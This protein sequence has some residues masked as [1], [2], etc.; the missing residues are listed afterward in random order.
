MTHSF[1]VARIFYR[2]G[3]VSIALILTGLFCL[4]ASAATVQS[5]AYVR[6]IHASPFI[7]TADVFVDGKQLLSSFQF[8]AVTGYVPV[9]PGTHKVQI[10]IMG[11]GINA[12]VITQDLTVTAGYAYTVA[13]LGTTANDLSLQ[14][15]VDNN[16]VVPN[17]AKVRIYCLSPDAG[18]VTAAVG[19]IRLVN[20]P[21]PYASNYVNMSTGSYMF[22]FNDSQHNVTLSLPV[23]LTP[24]TVASV[25]AVGLFNGNPKVQ[26]VPAVVPGIPG[27]PGTGSDPNLLDNVTIQPFLTW[28]LVGLLLVL[29]GIWPAMRYLKRT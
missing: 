24:D 12:S 4:P 9:P 5:P 14:V 6:I 25:F 27:L 15:Y 1:P 28:L 7:G 16:L 8:A 3:I 2:I 18:A 20:P 19:E 21:Y 23:T 22:S 13:A 17:Q 26:L 29:I 11:K 10:A